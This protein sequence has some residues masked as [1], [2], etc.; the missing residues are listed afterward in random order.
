VYN[1]LPCPGFP[2]LLAH[3]MLDIYPCPVQVGGKCP[4]ESERVAG[5]PVCFFSLRSIDTMPQAFIC[6]ILSPGSLP[7]NHCCSKPAVRLLKCAFCCLLPLPRRLLYRSPINTRSPN[8]SQF[9]EPH[10]AVG[11]DA[12]NSLVP[13]TG[14]KFDKL[15]DLLLG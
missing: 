11:K 1:G 14:A 5:K 6:Q 9:P 4:P 12:D 10:A 3:D 13:R 15:I 2:S 7:F 8:T